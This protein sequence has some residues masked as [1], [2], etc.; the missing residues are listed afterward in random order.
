M[1]PK[2]IS[3]AMA[4]AFQAV[5]RF[6]ADKGIKSTGNALSVYITYD[7]DKTPFRVSFLVSDENATKAESDVKADGR[8]PPTARPAQTRRWP[9]VPMPTVK[10]QQ[11]AMV[12]TAP[13]QGFSSVQTT[14]RK[15][16]SAVPRSQW[17]RRAESRA[18]MAGTVEIVSR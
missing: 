9:A 17:R 10:A 1:D 12:L 3:K 5:A 2:D 4:S 15:T 18:I 14:R 7:P 6:I 8:T 13:M 16:R 11:I